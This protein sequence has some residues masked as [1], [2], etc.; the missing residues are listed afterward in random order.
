MLIYCWRDGAL[1]IAATLP[2]GA[3]ELARGGKVGLRRLLSQAR[4]PAQPVGIDRLAGLADAPDEQQAIERLRCH[5]RRLE[6]QAG[7]G[8]RFNHALDLR[9]LGTP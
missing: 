2:S 9:F 4:D 8:V 6:E 7:D 1:G 5:I 3:I